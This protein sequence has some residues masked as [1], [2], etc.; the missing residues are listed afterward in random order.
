[1]KR[2]LIFAPLAALLT[3]CGGG[4]RASACGITAIAGATMLL[5]EFGVP[6]Q[7]LSEPPSQLPQRLV[8]RIAA[9]PALSAVVGRAEDGSLL[10]GAEG[11]LPAT[12][13]PLFGV[14][15]VD[16]KNTARGVML[17]ESEPI[18]GAP[19]IGKV[20]LDTLMLPLLG[21]QTDPSRFEE[22]KCPL[23]PDSIAS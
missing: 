8:A 1:M 12:I 2:A 16:P 9:G 7:T 21:V 3:A 22:P 6:Q 17:F 20:A 13:K 4:S 11:T 10:V 23:F 19:V 18:K 5:Q 14:L 15:V